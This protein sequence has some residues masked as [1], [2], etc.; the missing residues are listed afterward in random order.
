MSAYHALIQ[1]WIPLNTELNKHHLGMCSAEP[2]QTQR[3]EQVDTVFFLLISIGTFEHGRRLQ[4]TT[5]L[6]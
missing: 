1:N 5:K 3:V 4:H 6:A 2:I